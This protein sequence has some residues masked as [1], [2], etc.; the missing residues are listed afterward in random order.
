MPELYVTACSLPNFPR[1]LYDREQKSVCLAALRK[2]TVSV[3]SA[4]LKKKMEVLPFFLQLH[5]AFS[6][7]IVVWGSKLLG[8]SNWGKLGPF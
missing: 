2:L 6:F 1:I 5:Q 4:N 8:H 3:L 7:E